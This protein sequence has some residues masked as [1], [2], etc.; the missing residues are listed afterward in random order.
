MDPG[1]SESPTELV[2]TPRTP[3]L[4]LRQDAEEEHI[5]PDTE[6]NV[7]DQTHEIVTTFFTE[8]QNMERARQEADDTPPEMGF[9]TPRNP[10]EFS[11]AE[12]VGRQLAFIGDA[13]NERYAS[14]FGRM[15]RLLKLEPATAYE[16]F[17]AVARQLFSDGTVSWGR[18][19]ILLCFG[20]RVVV[21]VLQ[22]GLRDLFGRII[23]YIVLFVIRERIARW[24]AAQG[25]WRAALRYIPESVSWMS[26]GVVFGFAAISLIAVFYL[27]RR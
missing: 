20:Y 24:I 10:A 11:P 5:Q 17:A 18:I 6:T 23:G 9:L 4:I 22:R 14:E 25:G 26:I 15:I 7:A 1:G 3:T 21:T 27:T 2:D 8:L 16:T 19:I 12:Q 13:V